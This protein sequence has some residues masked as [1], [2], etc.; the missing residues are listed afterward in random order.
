MKEF[1]LIWC[2][3]HPVL[4]LAD[5]FRFSL[6]EDLATTQDRP[7]LMLL[8]SDALPIIDIGYTD[9]FDTQRYQPLHEH[10][11]PAHA[12]G[13]QLV[14]SANT[15][16][17]PVRPYVH[18]TIPDVWRVILP[19]NWPYLENPIRV[20]WQTQASKNQQ[21]LHIEVEPWV[22]RRYK[23]AD[24]REMIEGGVNVRIAV[25]SIEAAKQQSGRLLIDLQEF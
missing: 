9:V 2:L 23:R 8:Q 3:V 12:Q 11:S 5:G 25:D 13:G 15:R 10:N 24:G 18:Q 20:E 4:C 22:Q 19:A 21:P 17:P 1:M 6:H 14:F 7:T 16:L